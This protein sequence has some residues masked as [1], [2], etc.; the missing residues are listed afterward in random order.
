MKSCAAV[1]ILGLFG[2]ASTVHA[3]QKK[4]VRVVIVEGEIIRGIVQKPSVEIYISRQDLS[5]AEQLELRESFILRIVKSVESKP[6]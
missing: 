2:M 5:T 1:V 6:F 3:Q 4:R